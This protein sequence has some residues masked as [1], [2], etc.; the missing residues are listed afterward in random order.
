MAEPLSR[1]GVVALVGRP[2][3]GKSTLQNHLVG[4]K[5]S[6]TSRRPQTTRHRIVGVKNVANAQIA[7]VDTPGLHAGSGVRGA[8]SRYLNRAAYGVLHE[9][10][11]VLFVVERTQWTAEDEQVAQRLR[12]VRVPVLLVINKIDLLADKAVLLPYLARLAGRYSFAEMV[13]ICAR[14]IATLRHLQERILHYLPLGSKLYPEDFLTD[15]SERFLAAEVIREK[16]TR[17]TSQELPYAVTVEI[18]QFREA[19]GV[20]HIDAA[21]W[22]ERAT[23]KAIVI[24]HGGHA[25]KAVGK[26]ARRELEERIGRHVFLRLWVKVREGWS[27]DLVALRRFGYVDV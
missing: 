4:R 15:R 25:L 2:N 7:Y 12:S 26:L 10:D 9:V 18:E 8:M 17:R 6:I 11:L 23:Q 5:I 19:A 13:P 22:V 24:G 21:I 14:R 16:I 27:D 3:V 20:V 1:S